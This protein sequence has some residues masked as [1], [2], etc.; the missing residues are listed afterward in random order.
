M[1]FS[2][3]ENRE[4]FA[5]AHEQGVLLMEAL[6]SVFLPSVNEVKRMM[7]EKE[8]GEIEEIYASFMRA[9]KHPETHWIN[10]LKTG[11]AFKDLGS[12]CIGTMNYLI[13]IEPELIELQ[14]NRRADISETTAF[15]DLRYG[16]VKGKATVSNSLDGD[17]LLRVKGSRGTI[18]A[19]NF[20]KQG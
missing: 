8:I 14:S 18:E 7:K 12:Y 15:A 3:E 17:C 20:W 5:Y 10:D 4:L 19:V 13:D 9:G 11:G 16:K 6:K 1:L 2:V